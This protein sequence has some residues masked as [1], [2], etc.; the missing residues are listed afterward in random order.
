[1]RWIFNRLRVL[2]RT[3]KALGFRA[4]L[5]L[6]G[7]RF[8]GSARTHYKLRI[9]RYPY[10]VFIRGG[11][12]S[13]AIALYEVM[14][15]EEYRLTGALEGSA[16]IIDGG[17][18]VGMASLYFLNQHPAAHIVA[19]EPDP[20]NFDL[21]SL[22]LAPYKDRVTLIQ[23]G[24]WS[25][26]GRLALQTSAQEWLSRVKPD[27]SGTVEARTI[28]S[29]MAPGGKLDLLKL[30]IEGSEREVFGP[31]AQE[32][33]P[34][35][36]NIAI[37]LHGEECKDRFLAA[38]NGYRYDLSMRPTWEDPTGGTDTCYLA[39]CQNLQKDA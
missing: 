9:P 24:I 27:E 38:L 7:L 37:E 23:G 25:S 4:M 34:N 36:R 39:I 22:N 29:L 8:F 18:N 6:I 11:A 13:D 19:I 28:P 21:C 5:Q 30:D 14:V 1:M 2:F 35:V 16:F 10:P 26:H 17:A 12:S 15:T 33:L 3:S 31:E 32:W 20:A